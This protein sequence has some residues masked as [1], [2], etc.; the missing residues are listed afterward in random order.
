[1]RLYIEA[2]LS[3][4]KADLWLDTLY[5]SN[6]NCEEDNEVSEN[7]IR[8]DTHVCE[9]KTEG[10][11][12]SAK[13]YGVYVGYIDKDTS[14]TTYTETR[15]FTLNWLAEMI[16]SKGLKL[17]NAEGCYDK[18]VTVKVTELVLANGDERYVFDERDISNEIEFII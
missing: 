14:G 3:T 8:L 2:D 16:R 10:N 11:R 1:M 13:W 17:A 4:D 12:F 18:N 5:F 6:K 15:D 7:C 9:C